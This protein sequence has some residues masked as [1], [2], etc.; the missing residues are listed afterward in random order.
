MP[1]WPQRPTHE[2][3]SLSS[4][5]QVKPEGT[6]VAS[7][8]AGDGGNEGRGAD[9]TSPLP[10]DVPAP[11]GV[12]QQLCLP[13]VKKL[14]KSSWG[15]QRSCSEVPFPGEKRAELKPF[16][17]FSPA[18]HDSPCPNPALMPAAGLQHRQQAHSLLYGD[19]EK[20]EVKQ[21]SRDNQA[22][23]YFRFLPI[24]LAKMP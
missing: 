22:P 13:G 7:V 11:S 12:S 20:P 21:L 4:S 19:K 5:H 3:C 14:E 1:G 24:N 15:P 8:P 16:A 9:P 6:P 10:Q 2:V 18:P 17:L 23:A